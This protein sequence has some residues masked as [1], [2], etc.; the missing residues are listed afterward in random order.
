MKVLGLSFVAVASFFTMSSA[1]ATRLPQD[2]YDL[3]QRW[4]SV[5]KTDGSEELMSMNFVQVQDDEN[6]FNL[7]RGH[8]ESLVAEKDEITSFEF[9]KTETKTRD[10]ILNMLFPK[11][12]KDFAF[13]SSLPD[14]KL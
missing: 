11:G 14:P 3:S 1:F 6:Y 10:L 12:E 13:C 4:D 8:L 9:A 5:V 7:V 2:L